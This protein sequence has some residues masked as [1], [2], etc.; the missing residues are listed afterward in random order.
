MDRGDNLAGSSTRNRETDLHPARSIRVSRVASTG[1]SLFLPPSPFACINGIRV[2]HRRGC[3]RLDVLVISLRS[4]R[5]FPFSNNF[6]YSLLY[7]DGTY[8]R[9]CRSLVKARCICQNWRRD[10]YDVI[11]HSQRRSFVA[12]P[13]AISTRVIRDGRSGEARPFSTSFAHSFVRPSIRQSV[14]SSVRPSV[15]PFVQSPKPWGAVMEG[16]GSCRR[17]RRRISCVFYTYVK[18]ALFS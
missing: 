17:T 11:R 14:G 7:S 6:F 9:G 18:P 3:W 16:E 15:R 13:D 4:I 5:E 12:A 1:S 8:F 10:R 2:A